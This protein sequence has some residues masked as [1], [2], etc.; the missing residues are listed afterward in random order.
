MS[1]QGTIRR[2]TL[3]LE[4]IRRTSYPS[5]N[6][7][8]EY[9][10]DAGFE[11][12]KRTVQRDIEQIRV[13]FGIEIRYSRKSNG[14][15]IDELDSVNMDNFF[16]FLD[17][18]NT[19]LIFSEH[20]T[21]FNRITNHISFESTGTL[22]GI[23]HLR[24]LSNAIQTSKKVTFIYSNFRKGTTRTVILNPYLLKEYQNRWYVIG[25]IDDTDEIRTYGV[26]RMS[27]LSVTDIEFHPDP[28]IDPKSLFDNIIGLV[29][30]SADPESVFIA[31][32]PFQ[33]NHLRS[34]PLH[35]SQE[36]LFESEN[37]VIIRLNI[38]PNH[39]FKQR[40]LSFGDQ[41]CIIS[42]DWLANEM[43]LLLSGMLAKY[44]KNNHNDIV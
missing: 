36:V 32:S 1:Q 21:D 22:K 16:K 3:I 7:I 29:Y 27:A 11:V 13:E 24:P 33:A 41:A 43:K 6:E 40:I 4:K 31:V 19:S 10:A 5:F 2:Y 12:S 42:P 35:P 30:S 17:I 38:V 15:Y 44:Q 37:E 23:E 39:E 8:V 28:T 18:V 14:Y 26:D 25:T 20:L 9:V 34:L